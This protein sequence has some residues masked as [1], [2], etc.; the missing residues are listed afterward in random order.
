MVVDARFNYGADMNQVVRNHKQGNWGTEEKGVPYF[1]FAQNAN[2]DMII[3]VE[4]NS[5]KVY[6]QMMPKSLDLA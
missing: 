6:M 3:M 2:F 4:N 1:P 5:F